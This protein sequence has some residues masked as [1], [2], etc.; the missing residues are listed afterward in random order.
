MKHK[1]SFWGKKRQIPNEFYWIF[2]FV[3]VIICNTFKHKALWSS[4]QLVLMCLCLLD[5]LGIWKCWFLSKGKDWNTQT[6]KLSEQ[7]REPTTNATQIHWH[8]AILVVGKESAL[9]TAQPL[10][11]KHN[12]STSWAYLY[13]PSRL[14]ANM[15]PKRGLK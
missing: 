1:E 14:S 12:N 7:R 4:V 6:K 3:I 15:A 9:T 11:I 2:S 8:R 5:Q 10:K 13:L